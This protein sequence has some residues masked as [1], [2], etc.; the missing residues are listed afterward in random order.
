MP[1][2]RRGSVGQAWEGWDIDAGVRVCR[3]VCVHMC[4]CP[5]VQVSGCAGV[6]VCRCASVQMRRCAGVQV[7]R[8]AGAHV[9]ECAGVQV[10]ECADVQV[11]TCGGARVR[12]CAGLHSA[13][14]QLTQR[15]RA[16]RVP[17]HGV[18]R[19]DRPRG[20]KADWRSVRPG[21]PVLAQARR[22]PPHEPPHRAV[23]TPHLH[24]E[25]ATGQR[26]EDHTVFVP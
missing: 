14:Q 1:R 8:C 15:I 11:R 20:Q 19:T 24:E 16:C 5:D 7:C 26:T 23:D 22:P 21:S 25:G 6:R 18:S 12:R 10:C 13:N 4:R 2:L 17:S 9:C 3:C